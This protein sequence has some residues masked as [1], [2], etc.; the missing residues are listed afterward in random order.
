MGFCRSLG[1]RRERCGILV[2]RC[3]KRMV[4]LQQKSRCKRGAHRRCTL[5]Y[6]MQR[7]GGAGKGYSVGEVSLLVLG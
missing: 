5:A 4:L 7:E 2:P 1:K 3:E 6:V